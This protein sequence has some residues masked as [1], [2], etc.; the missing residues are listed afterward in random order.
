MKKNLFFHVVML[1]LMVFSQTITVVDHVSTE[2]L[3][4]VLIYS[5]VPPLHTSTNARGQA[6][7]S[8]FAGA[9]SIQ[10]SLLTY[11][12]RTF[13][14]S[15]LI[16]TKKIELRSASVSLD[17][18]VVSANRW[19]EQ[20]SENP[21]KI[22][23]LTRR[24][25]MLQNPQ[26]SADLL[27]TSGYVFVQKSQMAGGS[28]ILRGFASNRVLLVVDGVRMNTA[29]FRS[30]NLQNVISIDANALQSTEVLFG[31]GAVM[32]GSDAIGGVMDF[33]TLSP[34]LR[35]SS[36]K[37][38]IAAN[39][40]GRYG[41][42]NSERS[43]HADV[44]VNGHS[45]ALLT[46][47]TRSDYGDLRAGTT[48]NSSFLRPVYVQ[49]TEGRDQTVI[50]TDPS[51]QRGSAF[52]QTNFMQ[53]ILF[54]PSSKTTLDYGFYYSETSNAPRYDRLYL[55]NDKDGNL[56]FG[57]WYY[58]PQK[59]M[60]NRLSM[61]HKARNV[62][63]DQLKMAAAVQHNEE[64]RHDRRFNNAVR[65][66][67]T[68]KVQAYSINLDFDK[69][70]SSKTQIFY[71]A[72]ALLNIVRSSAL[73]K[74]IVTGEQSPTNTRYPDNSSWQAYG[75]YLNFRYKPANRLTLNAGV[76]YSHYQIRADFDT[77]FFPFPF[78]TARNNNGALNGGLGLV[79][80][81]TDRT[82]LYTNLSTG[83][84]AP[85]IDDM[86]KVF[87]S[88]P[89]T[90]VVP[91]PAL[92]P[93]YAY[94]AEVGAVKTLGRFLKIDGAVYYT[95]LTN[96]LARRDFNFNGADSIDYEGEKSRVMAIQNVSSAYVYGLQAGISVMLDKGFSLISKINY[97]KG[98][99]QSDDSLKWYP[100]SHVP[101]F[102][103][104]TE[105]NYTRKKLVLSFYAVY[106]A[107]M[108]YN[109]L[110]ITDRVDDAPFAK[111][112]N[113]LP[114]VP[115]WHTFNFKF[116]WYASSHLMLSGG[117]ENITDQLY[118][119][120]SSGIS[121]AGRNYIISLRLKI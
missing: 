47:F 70:I 49:R 117:I 40:F 112:D 59:W 41:S 92:K 4:G 90:V 69:K 100:K 120:F 99:E 71:G 81:P 76:R 62:M 35:D 43:Y 20:A 15:E 38:K 67:Q 73:R 44:A 50:N 53:K 3:P 74:N 107:R 34:V 54:K 29:I 91:N 45:L 42:A 77:L 55:D 82:R 66:D 115:A 16:Q 94:N 24:S 37:K 64:S 93:E 72:E 119:P 86:G 110:S 27:E 78:V 30:G 75:A 12:T 114:F 48:G 98:E 101:P 58:G 7:I 25:M 118:R 87:D 11:Q 121:A 108:D 8:I 116:I 57:E 6:D 22:E 60:M 17:E 95:L 14:Y 1:P 63:F 51:L 19:E 61:L 39:V 26:T 9:D 105:L 2:R 89:G 106:H 84:R 32:Y 13:G 33:H 85:N 21:N 104:R 18:I 88:Q 109:Q 31:P 65:R 96:A 68:E 46:S 5:R 10:F 97:Q 36:D 103:G 23:K 83:F 56:D 52:S 111:S 102:F 79:W 113:G 80:Q 28:P